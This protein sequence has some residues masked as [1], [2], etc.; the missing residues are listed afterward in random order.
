[1]PTVTAP[2]TVH[3]E[4]CMGTVFSFDIRD[5]GDWQAAIAEAVAWLHTVDATYSTY[6]E[7]SVISRLARGEVSLDESSAQV[8]EVFALCERVSLET[9]GF[10]SIHAGPD[11]ALDPSGMV[12]GWAIERASDLLAVHGSHNHAVNGGGDIQLEG[13]SAPGQ[14][15]RVGISDPGRAGTV[16]TVVAG[17]DLAVATSGMAERGAHI[18]DPHTGKPANALASV[19]IVGR[20]LTFADAYATAAHAM[21][22]DALDWVESLAGFEGLVVLADGTRQATSGWSALVSGR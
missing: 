8:R 9:K 14:P 13:E 6:R 7:D 22:L 4:H 5:P 16:L 15:W 20:Q 11:G 3:V 2:R 18:I 10:F 1:M 12:K 21:G 19:T 17:R